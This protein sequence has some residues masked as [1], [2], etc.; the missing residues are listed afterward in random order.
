MCHLVIGACLVHI[1]QKL[2]LIQKRCINIFCIRN[3]NI[4]TRG[5]MYAYLI[6]TFL[7]QKLKVVF[8]RTLA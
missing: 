1:F 3:N 4:F 8:D 2:A 7:E 5:R 6:T